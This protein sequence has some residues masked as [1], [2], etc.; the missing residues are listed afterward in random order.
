MSMAVFHCEASP[1]VGAGHVMRCLSVAD[2]LSWASWRVTFECSEE[3]QRTVP[4][5]ARSGYPVSAKQSDFAGANE[6]HFLDNYSLTAA[7]EYRL[8]RG[9]PRIAF[10]DRPNRPH[11]VD[12]LVDVTPGRQ[13]ADYQGLVPGRTS[14]CLGPTYAPLGLRWL[15]ARSTLARRTGHRARRVLVSMGMTDPSNASKAVVRGLIETGLDIQI[16]VVLGAAAPYLE[17]LRSLG[18]HGVTVHV[19]PPNFPEL[20]ASADFAVGSAGLSAYE[21]ACL[22]LPSLVFVVADNQVDLAA[23]LEAAGM[24]TVLD[25]TVL[26]NPAQLRNSLLGFAEGLHEVALQL[27]KAERVVDGR[28]TQRLLIAAAALTAPK[29][30]CVRLRLMEQEDCDWLFDLQ[31]LPE[32]RRHARNP[33]APARLEHDTWFDRL[34]RDSDRLPC[35]IENGRERVG[36]V[37]IDRL[38]NDDAFEVSIAIHPMM[39]GRNFGSDALRWLRHVVPAMDLVATIAPENT[40]SQA[41]F[42]QAGYKLDG[43]NT[44]RNRV[45]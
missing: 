2:T 24:V 39:H 37:R 4:T 41:L 17:D 20:V 3:T 43:D 34:L 30:Y 44:Y 38:R 19:D 8:A 11:D 31:N 6:V 22:L 32:T 13:A 45:S 5:L 1:K 18:K 35:V 28:G 29:S 40:R 21:R 42:R 10:E 23:A 36:F 14:F 26:G 15:K 16:D 12:I 25:R 27:E 7:D 9:A 33:A